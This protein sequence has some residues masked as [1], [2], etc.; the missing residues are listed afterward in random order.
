MGLWAQNYKGQEQIATITKKR[1]T[2]YILATREKRFGRTLNPPASGG[3]GILNQHRLNQPGRADQSQSSSGWSC[4]QR[5]MASTSVWDIGSE[6]SIGRSTLTV[7][8]RN[9]DYSLGR[10]TLVPD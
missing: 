1:R 7:W 2:T 6:V 10:P 4:H 3:F 9:R 8:G 5:L